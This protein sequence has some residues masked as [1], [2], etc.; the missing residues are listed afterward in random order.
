VIYL[1]YLEICDCDRD[2]YHYYDCQC[3]GGCCCCYYLDEVELLS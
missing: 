1:C 3:D 2:G